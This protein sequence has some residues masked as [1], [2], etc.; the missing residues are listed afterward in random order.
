MN[1]HDLVSAI[2][3]K[4][5][6]TLQEA[7]YVLELVFEVIEDALVNGETVKIPGFGV[8]SVKDK[9]PRKGVI[10]GTDTQIEIPGKRVV[11]YKASKT[12]KERL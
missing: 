12:L 7:S 3:E 1:K 11:T 9:A 10:P 6:T 2:A 4:N 8:F 5:G